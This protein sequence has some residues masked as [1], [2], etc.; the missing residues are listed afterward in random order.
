[1]YELFP[2]YHATKVLLN[3]A[4]TWQYGNQLILIVY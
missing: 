1:M 4:K 2:F 3:S